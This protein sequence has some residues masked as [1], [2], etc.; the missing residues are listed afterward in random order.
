MK[1]TLITIAAGALLAGCTLNNSFPK[2][3]ISG[4]LG[5]KPFSIQS[6]KD[7]DVTGL[8]ITAATNGTIRIRVDRVSASLSAS[9]IAAVADGQ[10][11]LVTSLADANAK[12]A[13]ALSKLIGSG[14]GAAASTA[15]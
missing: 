6:P 1:K 13:D 10:S 15:K 11:K 3:S 2:T 14:V 8:E 9:N 12:T 4:S 5:G 7:S